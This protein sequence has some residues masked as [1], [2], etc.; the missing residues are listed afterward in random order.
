MNS[1]RGLCQQE[2]CC[3]QINL[4]LRGRGR[5]AGWEPGLLKAAPDFPEKV[6]G[7]LLSWLAFSLRVP[8]VPG[9]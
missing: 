8:H 4:Q 1:A 7:F 3:G 5:N 6:R 2:E 9:R